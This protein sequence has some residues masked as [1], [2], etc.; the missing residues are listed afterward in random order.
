MI[1]RIIPIRLPILI[2]DNYNTIKIA[3][4]KVLFYYNLASFVYNNSKLVYNID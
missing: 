3:P 2:I 1:Y 4:F